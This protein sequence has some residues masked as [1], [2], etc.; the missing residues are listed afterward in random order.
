MFK[1][2]SKV[3]PAPALFA[4]PIDGKRKGGGIDLLP[5]SE[6]SAVQKGGRAAA[7]VVVLLL[8]FFFMGGV[9]R[10]AGASNQSA[11]SQSSKDPLT[12]N[13]R[14]DGIESLCKVFQIYGIPTDQ[15]N[16]VGSAKNAASMF[17]LG[18][19]QSP[20][21]SF[22]ILTT[23]AGEFSAGRLSDQDCAEVGEPLAKVASPRAGSTP[24]FDEAEHAFYY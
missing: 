8:I 23:I 9:L 24:S 11:A 19:D 16:A 10:N 4:P 7:G 21:R 14:K 22:F 2:E 3:R 17:K 5:W 13:D 1:P 18:D 15:K 12:D 20:E 6:L